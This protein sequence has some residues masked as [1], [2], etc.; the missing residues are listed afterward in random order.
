MI[1]KDQPAELAI[2]NSYFIEEVAMGLWHSH[3]V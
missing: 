1:S 2:A 3:N